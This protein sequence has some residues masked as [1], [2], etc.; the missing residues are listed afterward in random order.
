MRGAT[1][2]RDLSNPICLNAIVNGH[3]MIALTGPSLP[4]FLLL[5]PASPPRWAH[6]KNRNVL[7]P[8]S[9]LSSQNLVAVEALLSEIRSIPAVCPLLSSAVPVSLPSFTMVAKIGPLNHV[10]KVGIQT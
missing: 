9:C 1:L 2:K 5:Q 4:Y 6:T 10:G 7:G 3:A 8:V